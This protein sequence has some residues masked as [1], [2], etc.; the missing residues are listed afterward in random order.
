MVDGDSITLPT[1]LRVDPGT[2][3]VVAVR[4]GQEVYRRE[5]RLSDAESTTIEIDAPAAVTSSPATLAP[6]DATQRPV[7]SRVRSVDETNGSRAGAFVS[8]GAGVAFLG[9]GILSAFEMNSYLHDWRASCATESGCDES[10]RGTG[11]RW[12][13]MTW[14]GFGAAAAS[15]A[16]GTYLFLTAPTPGN[17]APIRVGVSLGA[18]NGLFL[19]GSF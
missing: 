13:A 11:Q 5:V 16:L 15:A 7:P 19:A 17:P 3:V 9:V 1:D 2:H 4:A 8:W 6:L 10:K 18:Q 12:Q 14:V